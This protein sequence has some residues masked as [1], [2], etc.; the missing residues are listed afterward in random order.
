VQKIVFDSAEL[1]GDDRLR[2]EAWIDTLASTVARLNVNPV[3]GLEFAGALEIVPLPGGAV[4]TV[5]ATF[6]DI[7]H[8]AAD[9]AIDGLD[10]V[11]MMISTNPKPLRLSQQG[12]DIDLAH[13]E[14]VLFDQTRWTN[15]SANA[16]EMSHVIGIRAP[17]ELLRQRL[18][19]LEDHFFTSVPRQSAALS[20]VQGYVASLMSMPGSDDALLS[21][22][23]MSHLADL[24]AVAVG[25]RE[26]P[27]V[28]LSR[29]QKAAQLIAIGHHIDRGFD[30]PGFSLT[31]LS[32]RLGIS[33]RQVQRLLAGNQTS[34]VDQLVE[35]R[36]R[37]AHDMLMSKLHAH[38]S[39]IDIAHECG[40]STVSHFH[41]VFRRQFGA[42]PGELR[43]PSK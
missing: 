29:G 18:P 43:Q 13:G 38:K 42:T 8:G 36:L 21:E 12:R 17:R 24:L 40:F 20:L 25:Q 39:V 7:L 35:R 6:S 9:I 28:Q 4:C 5:G 32:H 3:P 31:T 10:T 19:H 11:V 1:P 22:L 15:L 30:K 14:A 34:F 16:G 41:R 33:P 26:L 37:R 2:K 23:A 27:S